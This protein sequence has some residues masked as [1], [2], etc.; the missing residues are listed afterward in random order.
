MGVYSGYPHYK[1]RV[2]SSGQ[3]GAAA[4]RRE[5]VARLCSHA[6]TGGLALAR[7]WPR[8]AGSSDFRI[9]CQSD[10]QAAKQ[11]FEFPPTHT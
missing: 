9:F 7:D 10:T 5:A 8:F 3:S 6:G 1:P 2:L 11:P 4:E